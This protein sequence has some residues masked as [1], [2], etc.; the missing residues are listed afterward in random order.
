MGDYLFEGCKGV[1]IIAPSNSYAE[2][3]VSKRKSIKFVAKEK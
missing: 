3:Y 1:T 2:Y